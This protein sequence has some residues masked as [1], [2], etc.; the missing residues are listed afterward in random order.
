[1]LKLRKHKFDVWLT[2]RIPEEDQSIDGNFLSRK[3]LVIK[4]ISK[5]Y[6]E[7]VERSLRNLGNVYIEI[8]INEE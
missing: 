4:N 6:A 7:K 8:T 2:F 1:M 5:D 3:V